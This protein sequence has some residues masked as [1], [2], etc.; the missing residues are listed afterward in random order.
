MLEGLEPAGTAPEEDARRSGRP[1]GYCPRRL[2]SLGQDEVLEIHLVVR[3]S[4]LPGAMKV[5]PAV[6]P[7]RNSF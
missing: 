3:Y 2:S 4:L 5:S 7:L 6:W 1:Q